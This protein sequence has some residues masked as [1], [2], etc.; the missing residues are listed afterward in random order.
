MRH[1][2]CRTKALVAIILLILGISPNALEAQSIPGA[3]KP[4]QKVTF[5]YPAISMT[6]LPLKVAVDKGFF[7]DEGLEPN[8]IFMRG[9]LGT[10]ALSNGDIDFVLNITS[11][12]QGALQGLGLKLVAALNTRPLFSLVVRPEIKTIAD[13]KD[14]TFAVNAFGFSQAILTEA[15]LQHLGLKK[16]EYKLIAAGGTEGRLATMEKNLAQGTLVPPP[17]NVKM[18]NQGYRLIGNTADIVAYP[19]IGL[20]THENKI[21]SNPDRVEKAIRASLRGLNFVRN[22]RQE[23]VKVIMSWVNLNEKDAAR[24]YDLSKEGFSRDGFVTDDDLSFEWNILKEATKK[25]NVSIAAVHDFT[26]LRKVQKDLGI[27]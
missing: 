27:Q 20:V 22:N 5:S 18:E 9:N 13:L 4:L 6:W 16:G 15:H 3:H 11:A 26:I 8:L 7:A 2:R 1:R 19:I 14:K 25:T 24:V 12:L 10:V 21:K 17:V 23:T